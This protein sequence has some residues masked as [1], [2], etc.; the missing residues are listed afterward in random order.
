MTDKNKN[1]FPWPRRDLNTQ[2]SDLES[3]ALP[4]RHGVNYVRC[5][6]MT[7]N[8][9]HSFLDELLGKAYN[10][11][12]PFGCVPFGQHQESKTVRTCG[13]RWPNRSGDYGDETLSLPVATFLL[14][15]GSKMVRTSDL[16]WPNTS[17]GSGSETFSFPETAFLLSAPDVAS[18]GLKR[19]RVLRT[20]FGTRL[21][22]WLPFGCNRGAHTHYQSPSRLQVKGRRTGARASYGLAEN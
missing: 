14:V 21:K 15:E 18:G 10:R 5:L 22:D 16:R 4:L 12:L 13:V 19:T 2:P 17:A 7:H 20:T 1:K 6:I 9:S 8:S 3:D 11:A